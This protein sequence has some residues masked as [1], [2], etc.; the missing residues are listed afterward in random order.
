MVVNAKLAQIKKI[1]ILFPKIYRETIG[2]V[3]KIRS[4]GILIKDRG[5]KQKKQKICSRKIVKNI[6]SSFERVKI[7]IKKGF[8]AQKIP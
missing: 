5:E 7:L 3:I 8:D 2:M 6:K 4:K 1:R